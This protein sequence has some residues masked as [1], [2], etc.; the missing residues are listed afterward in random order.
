MPHDDSPRGDPP[1]RYSDT[2]V[3][4]LLKYATEL[5]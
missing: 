3:G 1:R 4:R 5:Q 2:E